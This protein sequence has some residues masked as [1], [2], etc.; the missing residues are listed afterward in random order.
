[1]SDALAI[2]GQ[3][4]EE[5]PVLNPNIEEDTLRKLYHKIAVILSQLS[6]PTSTRIGS[7]I[8]GSNGQLSVAG[9]PIT[10]N[11]N[12]MIQ[13]ANIPKAVLPEPHQTYESADGWYTA[14]A[15]MHMAQLLFQHND[16]VRSENDCRNKYVARFLFHYLAKQGQL[17]SFGFSDDDWSAQSRVSKFTCAMPKESDGFRLW[18]D[19]LRPVNLLVN[20]EDDIIAAIDWEFTYVAPMQFSLDPPWWLLLEALEMWS[21]GIDD[22]ADLY[23][24]RLTTWLLAMEDTENDE[25]RTSP[26]KLSDYI[27]ESWS[28]VLDGKEANDQSLMLR[29]GT[30]LAFCAKASLG[31][32]AVVA[33]QQRA[34]LVIRH[35]MARIDTVDSIFTANTDIFSLLTWSSI[36]KAKIG[37]LIAIYCWITPLVVVLTSETLSV[38]V[39]SRVV[40]GTC[41]NVRTLNFSNEK[42]FYW[43]N[44]TQIDGLYLIPVSEW[45][46]T[47][48][49]DI[50]TLAEPS[51]FDYWSRP[52]QQWQDMIAS[53]VALSNEPLVRKGT[54]EEICSS[55]WNCSYVLNF[56]A[57]GYKCE[58]LASGIDSK[59]QSLGQSTPPFNTSVLAPSGDMV[60]HAVND[61]GEYGDSQIPS[62]DSGFPKQSPPFPKNLGAFRTEPIMWIGYCTVED[63]SKSQ[64]NSEDVEG[65]HTA[66]T[67]VIFGCE[68]YEVN[69]TIQFD[70]VGGVQSHKVLH[71][72]YLRKPSDV[73]EYRLTGAY[74]SLGYALRRIFNGTTTMPRYDVQSKL[75]LTPLIDRLNYLPVKNLPEAIVQ[76]YE[77]MIIS[78][79]AE[80]SINVVSWASNGE[81]SGAAK[82]GPSTNYPCQKQRYTNVFE[83][84]KV[85]LLAVYAAS[86]ALA[87]AAVLLGLQAYREEGRMRDMKPSSIIAASRASEL[88]ESGVKGEARIGY[89][90]VEEN[91][92]NVRSFGVEGNVTQQQSQRV[93]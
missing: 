48:P 86:I 87:T 45:N 91:G 70:Y 47:Y 72:D 88:H 62:D 57:P 93:Y 24:E 75:L 22:W 50:D 21:Q 41:P 90:L 92:R 26:F 4:L 65:W 82:G 13:L 80:P 55:S 6:R 67:P 7:L 32:A 39:G 35:K 43:R 1:M 83:Y 61:L 19:D 71:R 53:R 14:S 10:Q 78:L 20:Q 52:S 60:Y 74:H 34:W 73:G 17:S 11:M 36:K 63:Y 31:T 54:G 85:Q 56:V 9:R 3:D 40:N 66:Y 29:Y 30:M 59:V 25:T 68:H 69:Y 77:N 12:S 23:N 49:G 76:M 89:G 33:F 79:L 58:K 84:N 8:E 5:T 38:V 51:K 46:S 27:R 37:T 18:C 16:L 2:P 64:P 44:R 42:S 28:S 81:P 15:E